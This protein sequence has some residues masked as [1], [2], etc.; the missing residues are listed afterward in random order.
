MFHQTYVVSSGRIHK[1]RIFI[2]SYV[3]PD[4]PFLINFV[5]IS[6]SEEINEVMC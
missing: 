5:F 4:A 3:F 6:S 1:I 2:G